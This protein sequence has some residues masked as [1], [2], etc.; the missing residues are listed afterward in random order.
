M[1]IYDMSEKNGLILHAKGCELL[2]KECERIQ[3]KLQKRVARQEEKRKAEF[4]EIFSYRSVEEICDAYGYGYI[5]DEQR[6]R[7]TELFEKGKDTL[8]EPL[9]TCDTAALDILHRFMKQ[10]RFE[11]RQ[12]RFDALSP[13]EQAE[14]IRRA[15]QNEKDWKAHKKE[16]KEKLRMEE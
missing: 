16:L 4:E 1:S 13:E 2:L 7:Y 9:E 8:N 3:A 14:E 10:L 12:D 11:I 6:R 5:T 15:E